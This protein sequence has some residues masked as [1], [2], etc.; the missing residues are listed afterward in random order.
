MFF[1]T[2]AGSLV[3][4]VLALAVGFVYGGVEALIL[5]AVLGILEISLSFDNA[6]V[7]ARILE[8]M[9]AFWQKMF[10]TVGI[11]IAVLGM[12]ILFPLLIVAVTAQ[13]NPVEAIRLAL[14]QGSIEEPGTYAY[15]LNDAHP[16]IAAFG[17]IFLLMLFLD[18]MF[19]DRDIRWLKIPELAFAWVGKLSSA[20]V[21]IGLVALVVASLAA[22]EKQAVVLVAGALGMVAYFLVT[23][24]G[25]LFDVSDDDDDQDIDPEEVAARAERI[26]AGGPR[27]TG[28]KV[29]GRAAFL[30]FLY[31][32]VIDAS[33]SFDGVIGAF[34][35]TSDPIL[36]ALGLGLIGAIF[37]RSLTVFLVRAGTLDDYVYLD[38][39]AH[40]AIGALATILLVSISVHVNEVVTGLIGVVFILAAFASSL[41]RNRRVAREEAAE[42][43]VTAS[44]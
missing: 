4:T 39:G 38:H 9:S 8:R 13:L 19:E 20:S 5:V 35:I 41:V 37:V 22:G 21:V 30:L 23:G 3:V 18:F 32:E 1:K 43:P 33:F 31:L 16:Q 17:G 40:W 11:L 24:L 7:N 34:A 12:R 36:I 26:S 44:R 2:F 42:A 10:L 15:I 14:E 27:N 28:G 29:V 6:V 25:A